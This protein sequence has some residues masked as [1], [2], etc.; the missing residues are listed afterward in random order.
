MAAQEDVA[1]KAE[2]YTGRFPQWMNGMGI[3]RSGH[4]ACA[5]G[6]GAGG[7]GGA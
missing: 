1:R 3:W 2:S 4:E 6:G 5:I 7:W